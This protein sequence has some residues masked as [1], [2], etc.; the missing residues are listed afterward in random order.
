MVS[1]WLFV[2]FIGWI[3]KSEAFSFQSTGLHLPPRP[4]SSSLYFEGRGDYYGESGSSYMVKEFRY[5][6]F[7]WEIVPPSHV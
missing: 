1:S 3:V 7:V 6:S 5:V 4:S 2:M